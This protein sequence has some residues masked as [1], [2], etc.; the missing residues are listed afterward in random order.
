[1]I[2]VNTLDTT[3]YKRSSDAITFQDE[4]CIFTYDLWSEGGD[5]GFSVYNK[6][7]SDITINLDKTFFVING[8]SND[9]FQNR[10]YASSMNISRAS[11]RSLEMSVPN[12]NTYSLGFYNAGRLAKTTTDETTFLGGYSVTFTE[13]RTITIPSRTS[14]AIKEFRILMLP[15]KHCDLKLYPSKGTGDKSV[16][17]SFISSPLNFSN[18]IAYSIGSSNKTHTVEHIFYIDRIWN[19]PANDMIKTVYRKDCKHEYESPEDIY[20]HYAPERFFI[21]YINPQKNWIKI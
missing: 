3:S 14:K 4:N 12:K 11:G 10:T 7:D 6:T 9:Y 20:T 16:S 1:V 13:P 21:K 5:A 19:Y 17:F 2:S 15:F 8:Y 18:R